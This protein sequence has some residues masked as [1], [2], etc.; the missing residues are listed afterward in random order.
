MPPLPGCQKK[1]ING[2]QLTEAA[3]LFLIL[4]LA[5]V[6]LGYRCPFRLMTGVDCPGCGMTRALM[7]LLDGNLPLSIQFHPF[8][9]PTLFLLPAS[10]LM[11]VQKKKR[12][13]QILM[14]IWMAGMAV[15]WLIRLFLH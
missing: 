15:C 13:F 2:K 14:T 11:A 7:A 8:L 10:V 4:F 12:A 6:V 5:V 9:I 3:F 1:R